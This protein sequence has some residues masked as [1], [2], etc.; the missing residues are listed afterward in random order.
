MSNWPQ[1]GTGTQ[2]NWW[3]EGCCCCCHQ[4]SSMWSLRPHLWSR[5]RRY[6]IRWQRVPFWL[7]W[8]SLRPRGARFPPETSDC[9]LQARVF[10]VRAR[11]RRLG[12]ECC[13]LL[14]ALPCAADESHPSNS[15][16]GWLPCFHFS[17]GV[18]FSSRRDDD[19]ST[20]AVP[21]SPSLDELENTQFASFPPPTPAGCVVH[22]DI[23]DLDSYQYRPTH[24]QT[25]SAA[26]ASPEMLCTQT[27]VI[28]WC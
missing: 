15:K 21:L 1:V 10:V 26:S 25:L 20:Q 13:L 27:L 23:S 18:A 3:I 28:K 12:F 8:V 7:G 2:I 24:A 11:S 22:R 17:W 6:A 4:T 16:F 14:L 5:A 9:V 19:L